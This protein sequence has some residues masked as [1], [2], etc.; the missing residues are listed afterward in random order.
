MSIHILPTCSPP[1]EPKQEVPINMLQR[2]TVNTACLW[3]LLLVQTGCMS[4]YSHL[5]VPLQGKETWPDCRATTE[6]QQP[7]GQ[8]DVLVI[9]C[10]SGGGS[11]ASWFSAATMLRLESVVDEINLLH[12]VDVISSVSGGSLPAAY[13]CLT[14]DPSPYSVVRVERLP[15]RLPPEL[16]SVIK[17]DPRR[18]LLGVRGKMTIEQHNLLRPL[19]AGTDQSRVDRLY[20]LSHQTHA[21]EIWQPETVRS[22]MTRDYISKLAWDVC[23]PRWHYWFTGYDRSDMMAEIFAR[24]LFGTTWVDIPKPLMHD[25]DQA[26]LGW[27]DRTPGAVD[28]PVSTD[29]E[30]DA[31]ILRW[32]KAQ[33]SRTR[34]RLDGIPGYTPAQS[35]GQLAAGDGAVANAENNLWPIRRKVPYRFRDLNPERPYLILNATNGTQ[36][37]PDEPHFGEV[38][39]FTREQFKQQLDSR[40]DDYPVAWGVMAS[41]AFPAVYSYVTLQDFRP[42]GEDRR[43]RYMHVFDGGNADNLGVTSAKRIILANRDRYRHFV[44]LLVDSQVSTRGAGRYKPD[45]RTRIVDMNFMS[46]FSTLIDNVRLHEVKEFNS[47]ILD[48]QDLADKLTFWHIAFDDVRDLELRAQANRIPTNFKIDPMNVEVIE[49]CVNDLVRP[50]H[51]KLQ[52]FLRVLRVPITGGA[53]K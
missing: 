49:Q 11:R 48:G 3:L 21:P 53:T 16:A 41:A 17:M 35:G 36:D 33:P 12:E 10:L 29:G 18:G 27:L 2:R 34:V 46:S 51:P 5:N 6:I 39:P 13:Y 20:W 30:R 7:R 25:A 28:E 44:V 8:E 14:R 24:N 15:E 38:F 19:F 32:P 22:L 23:V 50:D 37:D 40:L 9:L 52:Q 43:P 45:V 1:A 47:G 26:F 4:L 31:E 42:N